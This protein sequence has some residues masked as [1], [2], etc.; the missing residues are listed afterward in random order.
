MDFLGVNGGTLIESAQTFDITAFDSFQAEMVAFMWA[1]IWVLQQQ[2]LCAH[3]TSIIFCFDSV[4]AIY[5]TIAVWR[6]QKP[7]PLLVLAHALWEAVSSAFNA[8]VHHI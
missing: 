3:M 2:T 5:T 6:S 8:S 7:I 1:M 4:S